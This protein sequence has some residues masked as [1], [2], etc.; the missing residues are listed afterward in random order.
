MLSI[1]ACLIV[2]VHSVFFKMAG[3]APRIS[4]RLDFCSNARTKNQY[5]TLH[6][7]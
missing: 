5:R 3:D 4:D 7:R 2:I 1:L 6:F